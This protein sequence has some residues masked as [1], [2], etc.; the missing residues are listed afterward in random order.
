MNVNINKRIE[1]KAIQMAERMGETLDAFVQRAICNQLKIDSVVMEDT[2]TET[3]EIHTYPIGRASGGT[4]IK[5]LRDKGIE[6]ESYRG[7]NRN[8]Y[9]KAPISPEDFE[10]IKKNPD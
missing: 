8:Y 4:L 3:D 10:Y 5:V 7:E 6:A 2:I 9:L 1:N